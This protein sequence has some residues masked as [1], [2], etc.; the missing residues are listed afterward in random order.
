MTTEEA[1]RL[2][3]SQP[4]FTAVSCV[5][6]S[7]QTALHCAKNAGICAALLEHG[8]VDCMN[9]K[10]NLGRTPL[11]TLARNVPALAALL[12]SR[13]G[14]HLDINALDKK[15]RSAL[16]YVASEEAC[17]LLFQAGFGAINA[18]DSSGMSALHTA[19]NLGVLRFILAQPEFR[20]LNATAVTSMVVGAGEHVDTALSRAASLRDSA[21]VLELL[22]HPGHELASLEKAVEFVEGLAEAA[23]QALT[24]A[25]DLELKNQD[26]KAVERAT[27][28]S[29][30]D[31]L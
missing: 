6:V 8:A 20:E 2:I 10:D 21:R 18:L 7:G 23:G 15:G 24:A 29:R 31:L 4:G 1:C 14:V 9:T 17:A 11:H 13:D 22:Q 5:D 25:R 3:F 30:C 26:T 27:K 16:H 19:K 28:M 12:S